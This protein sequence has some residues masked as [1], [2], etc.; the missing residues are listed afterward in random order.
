M[1]HL[2]FPGVRSA[3]PFERP[4]VN[5]A[6]HDRQ[7][8]V[9]CALLLLVFGYGATGCAPKA[10]T[11][12]V[13]GPQFSVL[14]YNVNF[15]GPRPAEA[16]RAIADVDADVVCLQETN[17]AWEDAMRAAVGA[18]YPH[19]HFHHAPAAGGVALLSKWPVSSL[20]FHQPNAGWFPACIATVDTPLGQVQFVGV[21]LHP[22]VSDRGSFVSG[23]FTTPPVR[24]M[25]LEEVMDA[26]DGAR[27]AGDFVGRIVLGDFNEGDGG[28]AV[29][30]LRSRGYRDALKAHQPNASTWHWQAGPLPL[31]GRLDHVLYQAPLHGADARVIRRG[32]SDHYPVVAVFGVT[33][34]E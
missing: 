24:R 12:Q 21:H 29:R 23:Y 15:A 11:A 19:W 2:R 8:A 32:G 16:V 13:A 28:R 34:A 4:D 5:P 20:S 27:G 25:E 30:W 10:P 9:L 3:R 33:S 26:A 14:T 1:R 31:R 6:R 18:R 7:I 17:P 22:P